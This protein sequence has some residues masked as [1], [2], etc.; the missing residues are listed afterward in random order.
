[1]P[2]TAVIGGQWGDEGKGKVVDLLCAGVDLVARYQGGANAGHTV[3]VDGETLVL[4]QVPSGILHPGTVCILGHGV[5]LDPVALSEELDTLAQHD[6]DTAGRILI[7]SSAHVVTPI[8][9]AMDRATGHVIGTTLKGIGP[10][11]ADKARR[12]GIRAVDLLDTTQLGTYLNSRVKLGLDQGEIKAADAGPLKA[13]LEAFIFAANRIAPMVTDTFAA[14]QDALAADKN[15]LFEGAQGTL[16]DL[17]MGTFP[18]V[19][20]S[21]PT[22]GGIATGLGVPLQKVDRFVGVFKA[23][24]TRVGAGPF[25]T[26]L[27]DEQGREL[28]SE[29]AEFGATTGRE[30]RCGWF[31]AVAAAYACQINGF[32]ELALTK[33]DVLD[34]FK[35]VKICT[36]YKWDGATLPGFSAAIHQLDRVT[37]VYAELP[38]WR[39]G[40]SSAKTVQD[41]PPEAVDYIERLEELIGVPITTVSVGADRNQILIR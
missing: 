37:P 17:D 40:I 27:T 20:S 3:K 25:P 6:V 1:M 10:A 9:K 36:G 39:T 38:G 4:H 32:T 13:E 28:Q 33:L 23:Y 5:V 14:L 34:K 16:L 35:A 24:T 11:Y 26:E 22:I 30:R 7:S 19:T 29:G 41:L 15:I 18:Y 8:H 31:D 2:V 12:L 21:H